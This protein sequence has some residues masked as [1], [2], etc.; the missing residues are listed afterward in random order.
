MCGIFGAISKSKVNTKAIKILVNHS[1]QRGKDSSGVI[2]FL[3]N[4]YN[5]YRAD[6]DIERLIH[7]ID[8]NN[9]K[10]VLGHS[11]LITNGLADNQPVVRSNIAVLHNGIIVNTDRRFAQRNTKQM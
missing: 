9:C 10:L 1:K 11:R 5:I 6:F 4:I 7:G 3:N 2:K 8:L